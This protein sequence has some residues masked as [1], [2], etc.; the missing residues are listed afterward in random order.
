MFQMKEL[1]ITSTTE[2]KQTLSIQLLRQSWICY[3]FVI[4]WLSHP[5]N[6]YGA[7]GVFVRL[8]T[9]IVFPPSVLK[10]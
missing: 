7:R 8:T 4:C 6:P 9:L 5:S 10:F 2:C 1:K 3:E